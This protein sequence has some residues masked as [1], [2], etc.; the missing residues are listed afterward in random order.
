MA[1]DDCN[2]GILPEI[3]VRMWRYNSHIVKNRHHGI[4][5]VRRIESD[6]IVPYADVD[7]LPEELRDQWYLIGYFGDIDSIEQCSVRNVVYMSPMNISAG[8]EWLI[9]FVMDP[10]SVIQ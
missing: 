7:V 2:D 6:R 8:I 10:E 1:L 5:S 4:K 3:G 9:V